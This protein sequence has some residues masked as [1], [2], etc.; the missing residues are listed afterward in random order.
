MIQLGH[1]YSWSKTWYEECGKRFSSINEL[2][3]FTSKIGWVIFSLY[4]TSTAGR[5]FK[6]WKSLQL[7]QNSMV[8]YRPTQPQRYSFL[9][10]LFGS[11]H[12]FTKFCDLTP[13]SSMWSEIKNMIIILHTI[14]CNVFFSKCNCC[15]KEKS[16]QNLHFLTVFT[17][18]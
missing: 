6:F 9:T 14:K 16:C 1:F 15:K 12:F 2:E 11:C 18:T 10:F 7:H 3:L 4:Q 17:T 8:W 13:F 5:F